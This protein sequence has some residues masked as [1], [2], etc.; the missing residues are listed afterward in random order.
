MRPLIGEKNV[1]FGEAGGES[2]NQIRQGTVEALMKFLKRPN[3]HTVSG[4][5]TVGQVR[6]N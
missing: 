4:N 1:T 5:Q 3:L 6:V 2:A